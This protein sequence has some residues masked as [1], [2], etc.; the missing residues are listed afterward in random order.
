MQELSFRTSAAT[1][2]HTGR[3]IGSQSYGTPPLGQ[4]TQGKV[5]VRQATERCGELVG[6]HTMFGRSRKQG[7]SSNFKA[8]RRLQCE[9]LEKREM[10]SA[11]TGWMPALDL[12]SQPDHEFALVQSIEDTS[13]GARDQSLAISAVHLLVDGREV[14][15]K[16]LDQ[17]LVMEVGS[18]LEIVGIDYRL[19]GK[20]T[21]NGKIAFEGYLNKL[22][23][24]GV[25][26]DYRD[27]RFGSHEQ[28]GDLPFGQASHSGLKGAW[29]MEA[30]TES[31][32]LV[33]VRYGVD[34]IA[35]ED[36]LTILTQVGTP[37]FVIHPE[38]DVKGSGKG[39]VVGKQVKISAAW[40]NEGDGRY[41]SYAEVDIYHE[42]DPT[43]IVWAGTMADVVDA[44]DYDKGRFKNKTPRD[45]FSQ[46]WIPE[47]GGTYVLKIYADPENRWAEADE[48]NN[49][50]TTKVE[51]QDERQIGRGRDA[52]HG[53]GFNHHS[54]IETPSHDAT[55]A[56]ASSPLHTSHNTTDHGV[57]A[58]SQADTQKHVAE[59]K[60]AEISLNLSANRSIAPVRSTAASTPSEASS[61]QAENQAWLEAIDAAIISQLD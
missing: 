54:I 29:K 35:V 37:D 14:T 58:A 27:G 6:D 2:W 24:S 31:I 20:A 61:N 21:V 10:L 30:G 44:G 17:P 52:Q 38:I 25:S 23:K 28:Q 40:G 60:F 3:E 1:K 43:K 42:S 46:H 15:L 8:D 36:R 41:R 19:N 34:E 7:R 16:S 59:E 13:L 55:R 11:S 49:V 32:S 47:L 53:F 26:T 45:G 51:V 18:S 9:S 48:A 5:R 22:H 50:L 39:L 4:N 12:P 57:D 56:L 33:M